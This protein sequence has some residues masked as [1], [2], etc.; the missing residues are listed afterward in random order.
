MF[1]HPAF[2][3]D[4]DYYLLPGSPAIDNGTSNGAPQTDI[5]GNSRSVVLVL[6]WAHTRCICQYVNVPE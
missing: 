2:G 5:E 3:I 1:A 4:G 6:T